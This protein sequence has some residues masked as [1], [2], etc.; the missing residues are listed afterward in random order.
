MSGGAAG[1]G[2]RAGGAEGAGPQLAGA[3]R[4][5]R[6]GAVT[7]A[8]GA[9]GAGPALTSPALCKFVGKAQSAVNPVKKGGVELAMASARSCQRP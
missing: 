1:P 2:G 8:G 9:G 6:E 5:Q 4:R 3:A 7:R